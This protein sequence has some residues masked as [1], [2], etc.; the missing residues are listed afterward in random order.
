MLD[1]IH[2]TRIAGVLRGDDPYAPDAVNIGRRK[3]RGVVAF[4]FRVEQP[5]TVQKGSSGKSPRDEQGQKGLSQRVNLSI[6]PYGG[7][8]RIDSF[9]SN[10]P[11]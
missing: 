7:R 2:I 4:I 10:K 1:F 11:S 9:H 3:S 5:A 8:I 6:S